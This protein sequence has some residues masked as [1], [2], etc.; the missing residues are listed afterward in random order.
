LYILATPETAS[1]AWLR[2][3]AETKSDT[4]RDIPAEVTLLRELD[5]FIAEPNLPVNHSALSSNSSNAAAS[6]S[7]GITGAELSPL[8][9]WAA[10]GSKYPSLTK[11]VRLL[12][13]VPATS[14][15]SERLFSKAGMIISD[16]RSSLS[17]QHAEMLCFLSQNWAD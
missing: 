8:Q 2:R 3:K 14:V 10:N 5:A 4:A 16:R 1:W 15:S 7:G 9:W 17:P 6:T 13:G 12:L 11:V